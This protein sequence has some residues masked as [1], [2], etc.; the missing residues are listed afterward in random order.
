MIFESNNSPIQD[1]SKIIQG[2]GNQYILPFWEEKVLARSSHPTGVFGS[3][4]YGNKPSNAIIFTTQRVLGG[5]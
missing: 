5:D 1:I 4:R 2:E 3:R